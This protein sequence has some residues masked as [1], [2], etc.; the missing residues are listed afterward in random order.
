MWGDIS[1][2][3]NLDFPDGCIPNDLD[4]HDDAEHHFIYHWLFSCLIWYYLYVF[5]GYF[6]WYIQIF[7]YLT[8]EMN[9]LSFIFYYK[10]TIILPWR[11]FYPLQ[12]NKT[13]FLSVNICV[14]IVFHP[15]FDIFHL[16]LYFKF[17]Y[18][19]QNLIGSFFKIQSKVCLLNGICN[20]S[21]FEFIFSL[22]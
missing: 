1:L 22:I 18:W 6:I 9:L 5:S 7:I 3:L 15:K 10:I 20:T 19:E 13:S 12:Y 11:L 21:I 8:D 16:H 17:V 14:I 2:Y 4:F